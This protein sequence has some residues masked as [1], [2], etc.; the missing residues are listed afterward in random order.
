[1]RETRAPSGGQR[2]VLALDIMNDHAA[3]PG[4]D[5][6][7]ALDGSKLKSLGWKA[8]ITFEQTLK[9]TIAWTLDRPEWLE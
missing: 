3:R 8:P 9:K 2:P 6:R 4:H 1:V 5:R 7:Y